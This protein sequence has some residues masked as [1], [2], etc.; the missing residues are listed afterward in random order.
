MFGPNLS[1]ESSLDHL[2]SH[3]PNESPAR[4]GRTET[5]LTL[6]SESELLNTVT[7]DEDQCEATQFNVVRNIFVRAVRHVHL[8]NAVQCTRAIG[9]EV[10]QFTTTNP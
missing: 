5:F 7:S 8:C 3:F 2:N 6:Q 4:N 10:P 9:P 1:E